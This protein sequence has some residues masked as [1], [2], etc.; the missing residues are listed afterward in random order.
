ML[1]TIRLRFEPISPKHLEDAADMFCTNNRVMASTLKGSVFTRSEFDSLLHTDFINEQ[2]PV[3]GFWCVI[4]KESNRFIGVSGIHKINYQDKEYCEF[5]FILNDRHWGQGF[6]TEIGHHWIS[7]AAE[8]LQ[9]DNIIA[10]VSPHNLAS[11]RVL[12]KLDMKYMDQVTSVD[13][14]ERI[15]L[16]KNLFKH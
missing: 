8:T 3:F 14:G 9:L 5:G 2:E 1:E 12:E 11:R 4:L 16:G 10:T 7:Y 6:A 13:R 15:I